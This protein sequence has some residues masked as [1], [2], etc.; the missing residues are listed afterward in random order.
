M[1]QCLV[2]TFNFPVNCGD[3]IDYSQQR[4]ENLGDLIQETLELLE[5]NGG[6]DAY[7]NIK[8]MVPTYQSCLNN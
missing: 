2:M 8:Y 3:E 1:M 7:V 6:K 4:R 5:R